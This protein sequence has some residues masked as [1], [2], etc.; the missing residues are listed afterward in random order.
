MPYFVKASAVLVL[1]AVTLPGDNAADP[2]SPTMLPGVDP[3]GRMDSTAGL[4]RRLTNMT[5]GALKLPKGTYL[6]SSLVIPRGVSVTGAGPANTTIK[7]LPS[8]VSKTGAPLVTIS[9]HSAIEGVTVDVN[10]P[11]LGNL[12]SGVGPGGA[13]RGAVV[14]HVRIVNAGFNGL[15]WDND[16]GHWKHT[17]TIIDDVTIMGSTWVGALL[18]GIEDGQALK[19]NVIS[20]GSDAIELDDNTRFRLV[21]ARASKAIP[22]PFF[23]TGP[24][25]PLVTTS[26]TPNIVA[27]SG[28]RRFV[29]APG[30]R[31]KSGQAVCAYARTRSSPRLC[32]TIEAYAGTVLTMRITGASGSGKADTWTLVAEGG[33]LIWRGTNNRD[34]AIVH[35]VVVDN[36]HAGEDGIG[37][38][39]NGTVSTTSATPKVGVQSFALPAAELAYRPGNAVTIISRSTPTQVWM[40]GVVT[41]YRGTSL[42]VNVTDAKGSGEHT[43]WT[44]NTEPGNELIVGARVVDAGLFGIDLASNTTLID[45]VIDRPKERG[46]EVGLDLGGRISGAIVS[47]VT[48]RNSGDQGLYFGN[49]ANFQ[50]FEN[51]SLEKIF[52]A[53]RKGGRTTAYGVGV[54]TTN[55]AFANVTLNAASSRYHAVKTSPYLSFGPNAALRLD[56]T[57]PLYRAKLLWNG[58][59]PTSASIIAQSDDLRPGATRSFRMLIYTGTFLNGATGFSVQL[60]DALL[61][62]A[63][64]A[65]NGIDVHGN[66]HVDGAV[67][68]DGRTVVVSPTTGLRARR[69]YMLFGAC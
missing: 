8:A 59:V 21:S 48:I 67:A 16:L 22:P 30:M 18:K 43:D 61:G 17:G 29:I 25:N 33:M 34:I 37:I 6:V 24:G 55:T 49:H 20:S 31:Y 32:G 3:T 44:L 13:T 41:D 58:G 68:R 62:S 40:R 45:A 28:I 35:P 39:E 2:I 36:R 4:A 23:Y 54:D 53:D 65:V 27:N 1:V 46:L 60:P 7:R 69:S 9:S 66:A 14:R 12:M 47:N 63:R 57:V 15:H 42:T 26:T 11:S 52:I 10:N 64:C 5:G 56:K 51:I 19:L 38:G 50:S